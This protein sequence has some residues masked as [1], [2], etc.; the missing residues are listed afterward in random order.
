[1]KTTRASRIRTPGLSRPRCTA[2]RARDG[3]TCDKPV[4]DSSQSHRWST[5]KRKHAARVQPP[6]QRQFISF[7]VR[8]ACQELIDDP[9]Y[10][11]RLFQDLRARKLRP[12]VE[13]MLWS[14]AY[15]KPK[16]MVQHSG[17]VS[18]AEELNSL[19]PEELHTRALAVAAM[20][21]KR[22]DDPDDE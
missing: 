9:I 22:D 12:A 5:R 18:L 13:L 19:T 2:V 7:A 16:E 15:G 11:K 6:K 4:H 21:T 17:T 14:Y 1:M 8:K 10:L 3:A 20:L